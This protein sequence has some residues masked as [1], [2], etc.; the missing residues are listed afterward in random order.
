MVILNIV[1]IIS[2]ARRAQDKKI[3]TKVVVRRGDRRIELEI[4]PGSR[5]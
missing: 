5:E 3:P 1:G 2:L 4:T